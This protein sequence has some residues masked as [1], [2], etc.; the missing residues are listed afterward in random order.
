MTLLEQIQDAALETKHPLA[1]LLRKCLVLAYRLDNQAFRDW[2]EWELKGYPDDVEL[3]LYRHAKG[4][5]RANVSGMFGAEMN[6][7]PVPMS[8]IPEDHREPLRNF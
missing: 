1:D 7:V 6:D 2:V 3:P 5:L 4:D 8:Q